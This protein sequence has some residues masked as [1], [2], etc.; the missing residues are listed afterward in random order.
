MRRH[1][2]ICAAAAACALALGGCEDRNEDFDFFEASLGGGEE[3]PA[4]SSAAS[5]R[6]GFAF[7]GSSL[8]Y[9]LEVGAI[10][11]VFMAH[12]HSGARGANG[13]IMVDLFGG[14]GATPVSFTERAVLAQ[15]T[16]T[17]ASMRE[18]VTFEQLIAA[19][20]AGTAYVNVHTSGSPGGE[21]RGQVAIDE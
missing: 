16:L 7:D 3:V 2:I 13:P 5:G 9:T 17:A 6:A 12:V 4:N 14:P 21:I 11:D 8:V 15:G 18:G 19:M 20:R 1:R 10:R